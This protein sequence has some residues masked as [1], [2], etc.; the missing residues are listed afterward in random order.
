MVRGVN[1]E[2]EKKK[3]QDSALIFWDPRFTAP[4]TPSQLP[5]HDKT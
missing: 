3:K 1:L 5:S 2:R 4:F